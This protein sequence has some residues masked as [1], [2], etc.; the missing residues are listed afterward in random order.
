MVAHP[1][2]CVHV[3]SEIH[4]EQTTYHT[5][6]TN[7]D[8][9]QCGN[10]NVLLNLLALRRRCHIQDTRDVCHLRGYACVAKDEIFP[11]K[12]FCTEG[13]HMVVHL[14]DASYEW[15]NLLSEQKPL[16]TSHR[17]VASSHHEA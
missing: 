6:S 17:Y 4:A 15:P 12:F 11:Q 2:V 9:L 8:V 1:C 7:V 16:N 14:C 3:E 10:V 13:T 5:Q